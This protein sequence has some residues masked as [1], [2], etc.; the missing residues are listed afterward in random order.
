M[1][2]KIEAQLVIVFASRFSR[3]FHQR[4]A[5]TMFFNDARFACFD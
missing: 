1:T 5:R 4:F 3:G 2:L